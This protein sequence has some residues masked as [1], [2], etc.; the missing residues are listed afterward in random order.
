MRKIILYGELAKRFGAEHRFEV[1]NPHEAVL[2]LCANFK[3][4]KQYMN[5]AHK[6]GT[7]FKV[8][9]GDTGLRKNEEILYPSSSKEAIKIVPA[10]LGAGGE[11]KAIVGFVLI[12]GGLIVSPVAP[13]L[14]TAMI[15]VGIGLSIA[16]AYEALSSQPGQ[17]GSLGNGSQ[18][19]SD[20]KSFLFSGPENVSKQGGPIPLGYGRMMVG[21]TVG[22][23]SIEDV[24]Q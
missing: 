13:A 17:N 8:F 23:A 1:S 6:F 14:S 16:G 7:A 3:G 24:D 18:D 2:A 19:N 21:S 4:F 11:T 5:N 12:L 10:I 9:V 22:S 15:R 20:R